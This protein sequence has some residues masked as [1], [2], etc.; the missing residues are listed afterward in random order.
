MAP[1]AIFLH[2]ASVAERMRGTRVD[3]LAA[4]NERGEPE[5]WLADGD[6]AEVFAKIP[7]A[8]VEYLVE[9]LTDMAREAVAPGP[10]ETW[11]GEYPPTGTNSQ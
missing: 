3:V 11:Y 2:R 8:H 10:E 6:V 9:A 1:R 7:A 4:V 5:V